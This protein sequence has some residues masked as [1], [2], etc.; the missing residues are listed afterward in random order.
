MSKS[1]FASKTFWINAITL[2]VG[3]VALASGSDLIANYPQAVAC[4]VA[5]QGAL[6][7][8]LRLFTSTPIR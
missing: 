7:V 1:I 4:L 5:A 8:I 6:N 3:V 2:T